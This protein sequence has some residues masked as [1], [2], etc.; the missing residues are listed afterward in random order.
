MQER[1]EASR[2]ALLTAAMELLSERGM[3]GLS[4]RSIAERAG[5][6]PGMTTYF[7]GSLDELGREA[8]ARH[9]ATRVADYQALIAQLADTHAT[10]GEMAAAA[11]SLLT[12]STEQLVLAHL[13][14]YVNAARRPELRE[15]LAP[16][17][18][19]LHELAVAAADVIGLEDRDGFA[20]SAIALIEGAELARLAQG[21]D[22][23]ERIE[24]GLRLLGV[25]ALAWQ[26]EPERWAPRLAAPPER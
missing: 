16:V 20:R 9:Y 3:A 12:S 4:H 13:E 14:V 23:C 19:T 11:A 7:F 24:E 25:G 18:A 15:I 6:S 8:I 26:E 5:V 2:D 1:G 21:I 22:V 17:L 10:P